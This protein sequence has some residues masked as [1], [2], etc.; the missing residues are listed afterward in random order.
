[1]RAFLAL[2]FALTTTCLPGEEAHFY[3]TWEPRPALRAF[4]KPVRDSWW[5]PA[6]GAQTPPLA[7]HCKEFAAHNT[8]EVIVSEMI[9]D[10]KASP[11]EVRWFVYLSVML[12]WPQK[13]VLQVLAPFDAS[14]D[15]ATHHIANEFVADVESP[16]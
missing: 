14:S 4:W 11:S 16:K 2:F 10:L 3:G 8:P 7:R 12:H 9:A 5:Q 6:Q 1:M 13:R 15:P